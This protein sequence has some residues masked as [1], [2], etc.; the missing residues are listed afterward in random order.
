MSKNILLVNLGNRNL[1][2]EY[3]NEFVVYNLNTFKKT[4]RELTKEIY[5]KKAYNQVKLNI[6]N[7]VLESKDVENVTKIFIFASNI[8]NGQRNDQDTIYEA[9]IIKELIHK[10]YPNIQEVNI[11][12]VEDVTNNNYLLREFK[13][14][15]KE[16]INNNVFDKIYVCDA[17]GTGQQ[18]TNLKIAAEF[19]IDTE[20]LHIIDVLQEKELQSNVKIH[21]NLEYR[22]IILYYQLEPLINE[23]NYGAAAVL[24]GNINRSLKNFLLFLQYRIDF[25]TNFAE[26]T[27]QQLTYNLPKSLTKEQ[28]EFLISYKFYLNK[29]INNKCIL[30]EFTSKKDAFY[31]CE[32][33]NA[34][35]FYYSLNNHTRAI[36]LL[37][38]FVEVLVA[39]IIEYMS[40]KQ[41]KLRSGNYEFENSKICET[42]KNDKNVKDEWNSL[43]KRINPEN[44]KQE[45]TEIE[46]KPSLL[47]HIFFLEHYIYSQNPSEELKK[48]IDLIKQSNS[49]FRNQPIGLDKIRN[50]FA[51]EAKG[52]TKR[53]LEEKFPNFD[54]WFNEVLNLC[55][56]N[57]LDDNSYIQTNKKITELF[58]K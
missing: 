24:L 43:F 50:P 13:T 47:T 33:L 25:I 10:H 12:E 51:H 7:S 42:I 8:T 3:K 34:A 38:V 57:S 39:S 40:K 26:N 41:Y 58:L 35:Q 37:A 22:K 17:G 46:V 49:N 20:K 19:L 2:F 1:L 18:K 45:N 4:F 55:G 32:L 27:L 30:S 5:N 11:I 6:L 31:L 15:V 28:K 16:I 29:D 56:L 54:I 48:I 14:V 44:S 53:T 23:G 9:H 52:V 36:H 21:K